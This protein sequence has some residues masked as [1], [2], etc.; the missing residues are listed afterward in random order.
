MQVETANRTRSYASAVQLSLVLCVTFILSAPSIAQTTTPTGCVPGF[1]LPVLCNFEWDSTHQFLAESITAG[2]DGKLYAS[3]SDNQ[4]T[5]LCY[6]LRLTTDGKQEKVVATFPPLICSSGMLLGVA[7]DDEN[8]LHVGVTDWNLGTGSGV[9]RVERDGSITRVLQLPAWTF[10]N[11]IAFYDGAM[12]VSDSW[13]G[14]IWKKGPHD[15]T[16]ATSPWCCED[17]LPGPPNGIAFYRHELYVAIISPGSIVRV[18][19]LHDGLP[20]NWGYVAPPN[21]RL[22]TLDGVAFDVTGKL[23]FT[24]NHGSDALGGK[25]G[26]LDRD[27]TLT[28]LT[29]SP[30]WL[31]YP[32]QVVFG[33]KPF[34]DKTMYLTNAGLN[35]GHSNVV[36]LG[37]VGVAGLPLPADH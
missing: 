35:G 30:G 29:D 3:V 16:V 20:G 8:R 4:G 15:S 22:D 11:G 24:V 26:T 9:F 13:W 7:F 21:T 1:N 31:D 10:P 37:N 19:V 32:T 14:V 34:N 36:S 18:P 2:R 5:G 17:A 28:I 12:Y 33:T 23:W 6:I 27:G 25:L